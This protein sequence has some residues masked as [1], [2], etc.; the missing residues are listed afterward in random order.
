MMIHAARIV[1]KGQ[2]EPKSDRAVQCTEMYAG[3][4][5]K[6]HTK[7]REKLVQ[8]SLGKRPILPEHIMGEL[9]KYCTEMYATHY[10]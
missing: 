5:E 7:S 4:M 6:G 9:V 8:V 2:T 3:N 10:G 1:R